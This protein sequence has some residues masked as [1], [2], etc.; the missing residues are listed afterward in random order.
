MTVPGELARVTALTRPKAGLG[1][2]ALVEEGYA[3][4]VAHGTY[5]LAAL[6]TTRSTIPFLKDEV[7]VDPRRMVV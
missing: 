7:P 5:R 1:N 6:D 4:K 3:V 2:Q